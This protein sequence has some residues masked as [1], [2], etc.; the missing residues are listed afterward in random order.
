[1]INMRIL[2]LSA[3]WPEPADNGSRLRIAHLLRAL[4]QEH[5]VHLVALSQEPTHGL[6]HSNTDAQCASVHV[7]FQRDRPLRQVDRIA[8]LWRS[9]PASVRVSW[10][11]VFAAHVQERAQTT[12]PDI[13]VAF[14][15][16][17]APYVCRI[18]QIPRVLEELEVAYLLEQYTRQPQ[19]LRRLRAWLTW[20]KHR[21]YVSR[22][23]RN[24]DV[25]TVASVRE[26]QLAQS[27]VSQPINLVVVPNGTDVAECSGPWSQPEPDT[28]IYP[29]A[30]SY[31]ANFDAMAYFVG[32]IFPQIKA[33]RPN[34]R[35]RIT[36]KV[37][38][39]RRAA[40]PSIDGVEFT[41]YVP[42]VRPVI[43]RSWCEVVPLR[44]GGGTRL[45]V[46]EALALGTPVVSTT[47]GIEGLDLD[48][49]QHVLV[50][51][52]PGE[53]A[54]ATVR[55][56]GDASLRARLAA[57]GRQVVATHYD[58]RAIGRRLNDLI[59]ETVTRTPRAGHLHTQRT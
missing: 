7:V 13:V 36:G 35:L 8:S 51:D 3:W 50:A 52:T 42:D 18:P 19:D 39:N 12:R 21:R 48:P 44:I 34:V 33:T 32:S 38:P 11:S 54:A 10:N 27:L 56:L 25:C 29:G 30:L 2:C 41:G 20:T 58:W 45:K 17:V 6:E 47:K 59:D 57:A 40:L 23:L 14:Q 28:L 22:L 43:A 26:Q 31:D 1:V 9:K 15:L 24:F 5:E 46:L 4:A 53:F 16:G 49:D 55:L 37:D